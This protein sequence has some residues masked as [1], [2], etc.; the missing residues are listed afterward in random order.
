MTA[1]EQAKKDRALWGCLRKDFP[2]E[3]MAEV[4][5]AKTGDSVNEI[6]QRSNLLKMGL[7]ISGVPAIWQQIDCGE[8]TLKEASR[9]ARTL[10]KGEH[11]P[12][13]CAQAVPKK[14]S[15][16]AVPPAV[17]EILGFLQQATSCLRELE[18][19][20]VIHREKIPLVLPDQEVRAIILRVQNMVYEELRKVDYLNADL[21]HLISATRVFLVDLDEALKTL[22]QDFTRYRDTKPPVV[23]AQQE[24]AW[25]LKVL[26]F[27]PTTPRSKK[28]EVKKVYRRKAYTEHDDR[29]M[30][31]L[32]SPH[33]IELN[34]AWDIIHRAWY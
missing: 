7:N 2:G 13:K 12:K 19:Q 22:G 28:E 26:G 17:Q 34:R 25:A 27:D 11:S 23:V 24:V 4:L 20:P 5:S 33:L 6:R 8:L 15:Q 30:S 21:S 16:P 1:L 14:T 3:K 32:P 10:K 31:R 18:I 9:K 29:T